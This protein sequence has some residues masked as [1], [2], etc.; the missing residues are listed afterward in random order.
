MPFSFIYDLLTFLTV[1]NVNWTH[2]E[3][4]KKQNMWKPSSFLPDQ[5]IDLLQVA[6]GLEQA[7][8]FIEQIHGIT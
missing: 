8:L 7:V 1:Q 6:K 3:L 2:S 4:Q 5:L